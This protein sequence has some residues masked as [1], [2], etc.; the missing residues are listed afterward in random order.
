MYSLDGIP[1]DP[2]GA[3]VVIQAL[4]WK[5]SQGHFALKSLESVI[6]FISFFYATQ[7]FLRFSWPMRMTDVKLTSFEGLGMIS[8]D[9]LKQGSQNI[10]QYMLDMFRSPD[11]DPLFRTKLM[12]VGFESV[13]KTTILDCLFPLEG[14]GESQGC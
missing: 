8:I 9:N 11:A 14:W 2:A 3:L 6:L 13:G 4:V 5:F 12:V 10:V 1:L 7:L